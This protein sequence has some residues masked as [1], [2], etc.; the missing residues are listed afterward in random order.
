MSIKEQIG[1]LLGMEWHEAD[2]GQSKLKADYKKQLYQVIEL[3]SL[4]HIHYQGHSAFIPDREVAYI[5]ESNGRAYKFI[6]GKLKIKKTGKGKDKKEVL[7]ISYALTFPPFAKLVVDYLLGRFVFFEGQLYDVNDRQAVLVDD[8]SIQNLYGFKSDGPFVLEILKG[9]D[10]RLA[11]KPVRRLEPFK[12]SGQDFII[13][14]EKHTLTR[15]NPSRDCSFFKFYDVDYNTAKEAQGIADKFLNAV[16]ADEDSLHNAILQTYYIAQVAS[17]LKAKQNFFISKSGVR[18]GKGLRHIALSGL[19]NKIDVE[20]DNLT[21]NGFDA[22]NAW[23]LFSGGEMALATEQGDIIGDRMERVLKIIATEKSHIARS[24]G[25]NQGL[26]LLTS[27][28]CID[29]NKNVSLSDEMN[30][31]RVL[32]QYQNRPEGETDLEREAFFREYWQAFTHRDKSPKIEG[33]IGFL[34]LS[35]EYFQKME[36]VFEWR[37]V[38]VFNDVDLDDVQLYLINALRYN[39]FVERDYHVSELHRRTYGTNGIKAGQAIRTIGVKSHRKNTPG[40]H[41]VPGYMV[42]NIKRF[43]SFAGQPEQIGLG[44]ELVIFEVFKE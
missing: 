20:L 5:A 21:S 39:D 18:T 10:K 37:N 32:I 13:D 29:T 25:G 19:F 44:D 43:N 2:F 36:Q 12:V 17:G 16:I 41:K 35:L 24:V 40:G 27:V 9:I 33:S 1:K 23:A 28:L 38:E 30:G 26:V 34:F 15:T 22:L 14:L 42:D 31:R 7:E 11:V 6:A 8:F 4:N 3:D